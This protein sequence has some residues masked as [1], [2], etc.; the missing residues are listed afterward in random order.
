[1]DNRGMGIRRKIILLMKQHNGT[2]PEFDIT[3]DYVKVILW[4]DKK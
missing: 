4:K 2:E 3:E 1:M